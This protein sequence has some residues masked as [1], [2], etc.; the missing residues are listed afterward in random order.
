MRGPQSLSIRDWVCDNCG[1]HHDRDINAAL[2]IRDWEPKSEDAISRT[3]KMVSNV[4]RSQ[5]RDFANWIV[6]AFYIDRLRKDQTSQFLNELLRVTNL[7]A[8]T[9]EEGKYIKE[10]L[11]RGKDRKNK[12][13]QLALNKLDE[14]NKIKR[15]DNLENEINFKKFKNICLRLET[16]NIK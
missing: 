12:K 7:K 10:I 9:I 11:E 8:I 2:N 15:I 4:R 5:I 1:T 3:D 13:Y 16:L 6:F 14:L